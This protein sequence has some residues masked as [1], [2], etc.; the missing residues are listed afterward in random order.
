MTIIIEP[1]QAMLTH[2][3]QRILN[4]RRRQQGVSPLNPVCL[5]E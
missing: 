3:R 1:C 2:S 5:S 4:Q